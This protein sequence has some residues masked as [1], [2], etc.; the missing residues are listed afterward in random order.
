MIKEEMVATMF[1][2]YFSIRSIFKMFASTLI[3][4]LLKQLIN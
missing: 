1:E 2:Q 3:A 4:K